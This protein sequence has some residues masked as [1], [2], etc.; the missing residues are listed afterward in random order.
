MLVSVLVGYWIECISHI[1]VPL[2][3]ARAAEPHH[4]LEVSCP[5]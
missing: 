2:V 4:D 3:D 1:E 5:T